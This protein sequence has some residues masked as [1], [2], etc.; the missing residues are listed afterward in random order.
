LCVAIEQLDFRGRAAFAQA[1]ASAS[2]SPPDKIEADWG[3]RSSARL[4][5]GAEPDVR[6]NQS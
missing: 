3:M 1:S 4:R 6:S 2:S 5:F